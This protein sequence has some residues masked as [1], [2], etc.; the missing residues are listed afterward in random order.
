MPSNLSSTKNSAGIV[1]RAS[2]D[3]FG[4][5]G[6][7]ELERMKQTHLDVMKFAVTRTHRRFADVADQHV[8]LRYFRK[9]TREAACH[10]IFNQA[11]FE[12]D[13]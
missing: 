3:I 12:T 9:R 5:R 13:A 1:R 7:H 4:R 11:F 6:E 10:G 2:S 8:C